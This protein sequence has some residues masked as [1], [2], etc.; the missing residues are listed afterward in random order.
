MDKDTHMRLTTRAR[1]IKAMAHPS[2]LF[3]VEQLSDKEKTVG[4]LTDMI[5]ADMSTV[6]KHLSVLKN[7]GILADE[8]RGAQV[9]YRLTCPCIMKFFS[10]AEAVIKTSPKSGL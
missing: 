6:S 10:C 3:I 7:I 5:G 9:Y 4:E 1:I 8:K 2:R